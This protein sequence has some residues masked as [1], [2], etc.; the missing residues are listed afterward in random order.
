VCGK[1]ERILG[2][3]LL[4]ALLL[5]LSGCGSSASGE[6]LYRLPKL[7]REYGS[8]ETLID[9][10]LDDGAAY[11]APTSGSNLQSVQMVDLNGDGEE[12][13]VALLRKPADEQPIKIY[14]F[15]ASGDRYEQY[16]RIESTASSIYSI[17]YA[18]LN[19]DGQREILAG[20]R[21]DLEVQNL[22]V[23]SVARQ[24]PQQLLVTGYSRYAVRD[25]NG[26]GRQEL[27][28]LRSDEESFAVADYYVWTGAE[29]ALDASLRLSSTVA[30]LSRVTAG[31]LAGGESALFVTGLAEDSIA[32]TDILTAR[33]SGLQSVTHGAS[34]EVFRFVGLYPGDVNGDGV[35][36]VPEPVPFPHRETDGTIYYRICWRQYGASGA[37]EV[38]QESFQSQQ[39]GWSLL[40]PPE[41]AE[42]V[43]V[44]RLSRTD[45]ASVMFFRWDGM[46]AEPE[47]F[48]TVYAFT[49][50]T[51]SAEANR[52]LRI[53]LARRAETVYA[54]ELTDAAAGLID[55]QTLRE[56]FS[57]ITAEW[58]T[59][60]N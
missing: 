41:W 37:S 51:R 60:E 22:A 48:L 19:G 12:E 35:T 44:S 56:S 25:M 38:V 23:Y 8:L 57:L 16:C 27:V 39:D 13:A 14:V 5:M 10:L 24:E 2:L 21:G 59:G 32:I 26:D 46:Q 1:R 34:G 55:E 58:T 20:L 50:S 4:L 17:S 3:A 36:E 29:L 54:A 7:P 6:S 53:Q 49:G 9:A 40:L 43:T 33:E 30:E 52:G 28:V 18:D 15:R 47:P 11:A 42:T 45:S 31:T